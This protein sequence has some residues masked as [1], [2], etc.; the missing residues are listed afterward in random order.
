M[1]SRDWQSI[2]GTAL[3]FHPAALPT[4]GFFSLRNKF[5]WRQKRNPV[6]QK[7]TGETHLYTSPAFCC[8]CSELSKP[9]PFLAGGLSP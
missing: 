9:C 6:S 3:T 2:Q 8:G 1:R 7:G 5:F 4:G